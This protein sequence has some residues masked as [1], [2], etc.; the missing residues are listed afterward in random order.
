MTIVDVRRLLGSLPPDHPS[1][2]QFSSSTGFLTPGPVS[3]ASTIARSR[4]ACADRD[5]VA[6][7][8][9]DVIC[10]IRDMVQSLNLVSFKELASTPSLCLLGHKSEV[11]SQLAPY[12]L[13]ATLTK[14][15][16]GLLVQSGMDA[17][18]LDASMTATQAKG[19]ARG[20]R[21]AKTAQPYVLTPSH[22]FRGLAGGPNIAVA[23]ALARLGCTTV[24]EPITMGTLGRRKTG[25]ADDETS[26]LG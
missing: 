16:V 13:L 7:A 9:P 4:S 10:A 8:K 5:L 6:V 17:A 21:K 14:S 1:T 18:T 25:T 2:A 23:T 11:E 19:E 24:Q 3:Y 26:N 20:Y 12:A 15:F 22:I